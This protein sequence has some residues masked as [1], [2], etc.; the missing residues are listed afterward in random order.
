M[1]LQGVHVVIVSVGEDDGGAE[2]LLGPVDGDASPETDMGE[3]VVMA[4]E[5]FFCFYEVGGVEV[6]VDAP[7]VEAGAGHVFAPPADH[8]VVE[9]EVVVLAVEFLDVSLHDGHP[10][11]E[12]QLVVREHRQHVL[13]PEVLA[14]C[15]LLLQRLVV[16]EGDVCPVAEV[17]VVVY[18]RLAHPLDHLLVLGLVY[19]P[20]QE[21][22]L[23]RNVLNLLN[24]VDL[25]G[26]EGG[27][28]LHLTHDAQV[29]LLV[30]HQHPH[31]QVDLLRHHL[32]PSVRLLLESLLAQDGDL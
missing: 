29:G 12:G 21:L 20:V 11:A 10:P 2:L 13:V 16:G 1:L 26:V 22:V 18:D 32:L 24:A 30:Y 14:L 3:E 6:G 27:H 25:L 28:R 31:H 7:A 4:D 8:A 9:G 23:E 15:A 17:E 5:Y 19:R